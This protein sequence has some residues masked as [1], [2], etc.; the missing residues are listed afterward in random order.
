MVKHDLLV[1]SYELK[2]WKHELKIKN[3]SSYP[4]VTNSNPQVLN[5]NPRVTSSNLR[6]TSSNLQVLSSNP[7]VVS[8]NSQ[9][10]NHLTNEHPSKQP[11][12]Y[13]IS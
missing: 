5:S 7:R 12:N 11:Q 1:T 6:V 13:L 8:S 10:N 3:E 2:G 4:R 9:L